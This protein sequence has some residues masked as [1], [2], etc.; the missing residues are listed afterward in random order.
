MIAS[1]MRT[2]LNSTA[3]QWG[4]EIVVVFSPVVAEH[5]AKLGYTPSTIAQE[6]YEKGRKPR[7]EF[8][9]RPLGA[10]SVARSIPKW[11]D[12]L[13]EDGL[14][15]VVPKAEDIKVFVAG[16]RGPGSCLLVDG[17]GFGN[18]RFV[19]KEIKLPSTWDVLLKDLSGWETPIEVK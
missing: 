10:V 4:G 18:S 14:V 1:L 13:P 16:G 2:S 15:P 8:G 12:D 3:E 11:I 9:S 5:L 6:L 19:T 7:G 17:W